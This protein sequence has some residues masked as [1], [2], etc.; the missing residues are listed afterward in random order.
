[1]SFVTCLRS[2]YT[3][4]EFPAFETPDAGPVEMILDMD[5]LR[6]E[7]PGMSWYVPER[8]DMWR[9]GAL[10]PLDITDTRDASF[11]VTLGEGYT[12][13]LPFEHHPLAQKVGFRLFVKDEGEP[14]PGFGANPTRS[15][16]D[17]GMAMV[18][19]MARRLGISRVAVPTQGNAGDSLVAY[20]LA[21][22]LEAAV[23]APLDAPAPILRSLQ[24]AVKRHPTIRLELV[25][26]TIREAAAVV[27]EKYLP[28]GYVNVATFQ[29]PGWRIE[30]KK[31][32]GFELAEQPDGRWVLPDVVVYPTGGGTGILGMWKAFDELERLGMIDARRPRM[33][34]V[35]AAPTAPIVRAFDGGETDVM[36][37]EAGTTIAAGLNVPAGIGHRRVLEIVRESGGAAVDVAEESIRSMLRTVI[38]RSICPEG[39]AS[40]AALDEIVEL[41]IIGSGDRVV[42]F[43]TASSRKYFDSVE[44]LD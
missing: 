41:G 32:L 30:G 38:S 27:R 22:G 37:V 5:R 11:V 31:T 33:V 36:P 18:V 40:L 21:A 29:E 42:V 7:R 19:S 10:L 12:P 15:F 13:L 23:V 34:A 35:Q 4:S 43:N 26:G 25:S 14:H 8:R 17:R 2:I 20:A 24:H 6:R 9:F 28:E 44:D 3:G 39:A 1:M 16:K